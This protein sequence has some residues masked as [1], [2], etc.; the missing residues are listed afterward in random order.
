MRDKMRKLGKGLA[1]F[2]VLAASSISA[3]TLK[4]A[5]VPKYQSIF[6]EQSAQGCQDAAE[7]MQ[8]VECIY[9]GPKKGDVRQQNKIIE[10]LIDEGVDGIAVAV[11]KSDFL[12]EHSMQKAAKAGIPVITYDSDFDMPT[13]QK[14]KNLRLAYIGTNNFKLGWALGEQLKKLRPEGGTLI[15]QTGRPDAPNLNLRIMGLRS[16]LSGK[17]YTN[18]PGDILENEQGWTEV[19]LP[20]PNYD[21]INR[22]IKQLESFLKAQPNKA[23]AF[24]A[25]GGWP[26]NNEQRYRKMI[27]PFK[28]KLDSKETVIIISDASSEQL[29]MLRDKLAHANIGQKPYEMGKQAIFTLFKAV[30]KLPYEKVINT[31]LS[32][33]TVSNYDSCNDQPR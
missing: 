12:A 2:T 14:Y 3:D 6:F 9:R 33:C 16:A 31:P 32:Y 18:P 26:Q 4:F 10:Q 7:Q 5:V 8:G 19:R 24:I 20:M 30:N 1:L 28:R 27:A 23:D 22:A 21:N 15:I 13:L 25:V 11:T 29:N 17:T